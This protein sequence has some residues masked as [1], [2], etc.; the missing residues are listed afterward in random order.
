MSSSI[1]AHAQRPI[2]S[3]TRS[4]TGF[5]MATHGHNDHGRHTWASGAPCEISKN[6][7][8]VGMC[9]YLDHSAILKLSLRNPRTFM[10]VRHPLECAT[11]H[12]RECSVQFSLF[13]FS[14]ELLCPHLGGAYTIQKRMIGVEE[15]ERS[16]PFC[17]RFTLR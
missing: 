16:V 1:S 7:I 12:K 5:F 8:F 10:Y 4:I 6:T 11:F 15:G 14:S 13:P 2:S 9:I 17:I 3:V